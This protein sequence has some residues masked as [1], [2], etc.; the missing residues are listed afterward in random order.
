MI[1]GRWGD[2]LFD[3][4]LALDIQARFEHLVETGTSAKQAAIGLLQSD[5]A[6]EILDELDPEDRDEMFWEES[7]AMFLAIASIQIA[8]DA[9][10]PDVTPLALEAIAHERARLDAKRDEVRLAALSSLEARLR[11]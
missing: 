9:L 11:V 7:G 3:D 5:L 8:H 6:R 10:D 4:D 2:D 1:M